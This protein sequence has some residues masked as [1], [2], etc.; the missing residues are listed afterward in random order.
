MKLTKIISLL[1]VL[2][3]AL[4]MLASCN[5]EDVLAGIMGSITTQPPT[6]SSSS[7]STTDKGEGDPEDDKDA[8][9]EAYET[10]LK[11]L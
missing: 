8:W 5:L 9:D 7:N 1:L 11:L 6:P 10:L 2:T 4:T 3:M